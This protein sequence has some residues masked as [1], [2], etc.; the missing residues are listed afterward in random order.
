MFNKKS[1]KKVDLSS[2]AP[3]PKP[4]RTIKEVQEEYQQLAF[5]AGN[6]QYQIYTFERDLELLNSKMRELNFE[7]AA[8]QQEEA[9]KAKA[10]SEK[11]SQ[12]A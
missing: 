12:N 8:I 4:S 3:E 2:V 9:N 6:T 10:E 11:E 7:A 1:A 5:K